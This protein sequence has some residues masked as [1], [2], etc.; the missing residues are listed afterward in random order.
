ML[1]I[2]AIG[3]LLPS[4]LSYLYIV[5][6][7]LEPNEIAYVL[8][9]CVWAYMKDHVPTPNLFSVDANGLHWRDNENPLAQYVDPLKNTMQKRL[10]TMGKLYY[11]MFV[12]PE[13]VAK[14]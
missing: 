4:P 7:Y 14:S 6:Q 13:K 10:S 8:K 1:E 2:L 12:Y 5:I 3:Q 9:E 11:H